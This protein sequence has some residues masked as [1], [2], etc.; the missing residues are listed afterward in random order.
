MDQ[1]LIQLG[2]N[3]TSNA[4]Y[5]IV[6]NYFASTVQPTSDGLKDRLVSELRIDNAN[7]KA[8]SIIEF[9][10]RNGDISIQGTS[11]YSA[12]AI[13]MQSSKNTTLSFGNNSVSATDNTRIEAGH[14]AQ[15]ISSGGAGIRQNEDGSISFFT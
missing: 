10:A 2:I 8:E 14:G 15:I 11:I 3:L 4:I 13:H 7:I 1:L 5:D 6:K 12:K 9:L